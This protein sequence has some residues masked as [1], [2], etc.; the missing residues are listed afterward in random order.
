MS[1]R[2]RLNAL[3]RTVPLRYQVRGV[4][5]LEQRVGRAILGDDMGLGKTYQ[6][7]AWLA[8]H[9]EISPVVVVCPPIAKYVWRRQAWEHARMRTCVLSGRTPYRIRHEIV[10]LNFDILPYWIK[11]LI[12]LRPKALIIDEA[13]RLQ[14][15]D[16]VRTKCCLE[17]ARGIEHIIPLTGTPIRNCPINFFP[18]LNLVDP[19]LFPSFIDFAYTYCDPKPGRRGGVDYRGAT[20]LDDLHALVSQVMIRRTKA[21]VMKDL[22][23]KTYSVVPVDIENRSE[24]EQ[25]TK[26]FYRWYLEKKGAAAVKRALSATEFV[27]IQALLTL[28]GEGKIPFVKDWI[29]NWLVETDQKLVVFTRH[30][31]VMDEL[32]RAFPGACRV[33]GSTS[34]AKRSRAVAEFQ[35][36]TRRR[37]F[38]GQLEAA[39]ESI[40]LTAAS[41]VLFTELSW[42]PSEHTQAEDRVLRIGQTASHVDVYYLVARD[43][44]EEKM[45]DTQDRKRHTASRVI[46][47]KYIRQ[48]VLKELMHV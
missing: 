47:T 26:D 12:K 38:F 18:I 46:D 2:Q 33:D 25:A 32:C 36:N 15:R 29:Q 7:L 11:R 17:L 14:N 5:F 16:A 3:L 28:V 39:G 41:A 10:I 13:H 40:T 44:I 42:V 48:V 19:E 37:L 30:V 4:R 34:P 27:R 45:V 23:Q 35:T 22:P 21:E 1:L 31:L 9:P 8:L 43:T 20:N 6:A 24:Y